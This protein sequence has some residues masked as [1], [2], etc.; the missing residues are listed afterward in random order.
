MGKICYFLVIKNI[1]NILRWWL[2][3]V[4]RVEYMILDLIVLEVG[5]RRI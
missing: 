1:K 4:Y 5:V 3:L 2:D